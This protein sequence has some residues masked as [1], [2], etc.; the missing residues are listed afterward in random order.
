MSDQ[1]AIR[2]SEAWSKSEVELLVVD[3]FHMLGL[4]LTNRG[5]NK[6][7]HNRELQQLLG[8]RR[9]PASIE[10]KHQNVSAVLIELGCPFI[11]GYKPLGNYQ[12]RLYDEVA[13]R[14]ALDAEFNRAA[15]NAVEQPAVVPRLSSIAGLVEVVVP[16]QRRTAD[17]IAERSR[18][19]AG[20]HR[21]YLERE[22]RNRSLGS[23]GERLVVEFEQHRLR[24]IGRP[25]LSAKVEHLSVTQGDGLGYDVLSFEADARERYIEVK[26]TAFAEH[27]PFFVSRNEV[28]F[29]AEVPEQFHLYRLFQF[30]NGPRLFRLRGT[31]AE[32]VQLDPVTYLARL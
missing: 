18:P 9:S 25:D 20:V 22:A 28:E 23:A 24:E 10:K 19:R 30:R 13:A 2:E 4:E 8:G 1:P 7:A 31:L 27:T 11:R 12:A 17:R 16:P 3:Y 5:Y 32:T 14:V 6:R 15:T 26:T 29:S 21:D